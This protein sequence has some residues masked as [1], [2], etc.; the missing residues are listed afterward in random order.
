MLGCFVVLFDESLNKST[1]TKQMDIHV[2]LYDDA[3]KAVVTRYLTSAFLGH[4]T[5][6]LMVVSQHYLREDD[7]AVHGWPKCELGLL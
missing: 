7:P 1:Q 5:A 2:H 3:K 4:A 6:A